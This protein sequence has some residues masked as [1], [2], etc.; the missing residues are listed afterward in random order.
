M[1]W[2][3]QGKPLMPLHYSL[4]H[5]TS[6]KSSKSAKEKGFF[7]SWNRQMSLN[8]DCQLTQCSSKVNLRY[9]KLKV[10]DFVTGNDT[11]MLPPGFSLGVKVEW[12]EP[13]GNFRQ[14]TTI[15]SV[16]FPFSL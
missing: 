7:P 11:K 5:P 10:M 13:K 15:T 12:R 2:S 16:A 8:V 4:L 6:N 14:A 1:E 9:S 3:C